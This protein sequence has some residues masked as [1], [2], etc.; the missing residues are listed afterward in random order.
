MISPVELTGAFERNAAIVKMQC[1]G[2]SHADSMLQ[3][4]F[5][6]NCLNWVIGHIIVNRDILLEMLEAPALMSGDGERYRRGSE[7]LVEA[8]D[9]VLSLEVLLARL[10]QSQEHIAA[11]L[12][13]MDD[14]YMSR[15]ISYRDRTTTPGRQ[16][17]FLYFHETYHVGQTELL[18]QL[19]G[20]KDKII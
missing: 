18:R 13:E 1:E 14:A 16:A 12:G 4:P 7:E 3:L 10:D 17:F 2:L 8:G 5:Q 6:G 11:R 9:G 15:E 20:K 19:A